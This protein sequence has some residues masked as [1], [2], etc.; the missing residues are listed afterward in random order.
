MQMTLADLDE[1]MESL[2]PSIENVGC[3]IEGEAVGEVSDILEETR[4]GT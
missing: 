2:Y 4:G 1:Q 3:C